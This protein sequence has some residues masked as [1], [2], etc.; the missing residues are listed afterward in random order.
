M[1]TKNDVM[2]PFQE[3]TKEDVE[4]VLPFTQSLDDLFFK[5]HQLKE[6]A[7]AKCIVSKDSFD[8]GVSLI[9]F[10]SNVEK[11]DQNYF[12]FMIQL[13]NS[14][15]SQNIGFWR[16][17]FE[18]TKKCFLE[19]PQVTGENIID[20]VNQSEE[21]IV[22]IVPYQYLPNRQ[23]I[24][25][26]VQESKEYSNALSGNILLER[27][28]KKNPEKDPNKFDIDKAVKKY[29]KFSEEKAFEFMAKII[30][31][32]PGHQLDF[33][34]RYFCVYNDIPLYWCIWKK[35]FYT[36][37]FSLLQLSHPTFQPRQTYSGK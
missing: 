16:L 7:V 37:S 12:D 23:Y 11:R 32:T 20:L 25:L 4:N 27:I 1:Q 2:Y 5:R 17:Y 28:F 14:Q 24:D 19:I 34:Q 29:L 35:Q 9:D 21:I 8:I 36:A 22:E 13:A 3:V 10:Y 26:L 31:T 18:R 30:N 6:I 33:W 15:I